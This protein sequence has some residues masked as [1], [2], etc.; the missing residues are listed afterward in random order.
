MKSAIKKGM[1]TN[2]KIHCNDHVF[3]FFLEIKMKYKVNLNFL[4][5]SS[6]E[7]IFN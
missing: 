5:T 6:T 2:K 1:N 7:K 3:P 4:K